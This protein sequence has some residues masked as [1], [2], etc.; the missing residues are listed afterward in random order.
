MLSPRRWHSSPA[1]ARLACGHGD[2][3]DGPAGSSRHHSSEGPKRP[4][5]RVLH[6]F[7]ALAKPGAQRQTQ[8]GG[9]GWPNFAPDF[10]EELGLIEPY[11]IAISFRSGFCARSLFP[12]S[13]L[14]IPSGMTMSVISKL[15]SCTLGHHTSIASRAEAAS[16][17]L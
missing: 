14:E 12:S 4:A 9:A 7:D 16:C 3:L 11:L 1:P 8:A 5:A 10:A 17:T 15:M 2:S 6:G 13:R